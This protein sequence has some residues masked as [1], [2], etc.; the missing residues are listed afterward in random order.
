[1]NFVLYKQYFYDKCTN[2]D[3]IY[4]EGNECFNNTLNTF[5]LQLVGVGPF[6]QPERKRAISISWATISD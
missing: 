6:R 4:K 2:L 3:V 5:N 1:M